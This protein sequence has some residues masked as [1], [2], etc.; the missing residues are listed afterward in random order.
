MIGR[1]L[2]AGNDNFN[3]DNF[4]VDLTAKI[5][6]K[7]EG[8]FLWVTLVTEFLIV[9]IESCKPQR[10]IFATLQKLPKD[11]Q[12]LYIK[13]LDHIPEDVANDTINYLEI[14]LQKETFHLQRPM[15]L[16]EFSIAADEP[17]NALGCSFASEDEEYD[18]ISGLY[19]DTTHRIRARCR[20]LVEITAPDYRKPSIRKNEKSQNVRFVH[21]TVKHFIRRDEQWKVLLSRAGA[22]AATK[23]D[24]ENAVSP[25]IDPSIFLMAMQLQTL[26]IIVRRHMCYS[27]EQPK[28]SILSKTQLPPEHLPGCYCWTEFCKWKYPWFSKRLAWRAFEAF[29]V[30]FE[31]LRKRPE[32][33]KGPVSGPNSPEDRQ[34]K[35][36]IGEPYFKEVEQTCFMLCPGFAAHYWENDLKPHG[37]DQWHTNT[38]EPTL[39]ALLLS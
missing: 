24:S 20:G 1:M 29:F 6:T 18:W 17:E 37:N 33:R 3:K 25:I 2:A 10:Q 26:K 16:E 38:S 11:L 4:E 8:V 7:A 21:I 12:Q 14:L 35:R 32:K 9:D 34:R 30:Y 19:N 27:N 28:V 36:D 39:V 5:T 15:S 13:I 22:D 31:Y 23:N